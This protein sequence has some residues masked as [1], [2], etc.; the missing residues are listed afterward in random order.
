MPVRSCRIVLVVAGCAACVPPDRSPEEGESAPPPTIGHVERLAAGLDAIVAEDAVFE[1]LAEGHEWTEGPVWVPALQSILYSDIPNNAVYRWRE[2]QGASLWLQPSGYTGEAARGGESGSNGLA[3]DGEGRLVLAQHGDRR[4]ARMNA[5]LTAPE[6]RFETLTGAYEG[7]RYHSPN[8]VA[9]RGTGDL[10]FTDPPYGLEHGP[11]DPAREMDVH[12]VYHLAP[13]GA[14]TLVVGDLSRPNGVA[15]SPDERTLYVSSSDEAQPVVRAY[16][17]AD[18]GS[19]SNGRVFVESWGDGMAVDRD[20]NVFLTR[21]AD[22]VL[23][24]APDGT[25]LGTLVTTERTSNAAFG[26]D[27]SA[28]YVTS[29]MY[30][31]RIGLGGAAVVGR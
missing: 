21:G 24:I 7:R 8:D 30:L 1:I 20:G 27:G 19:L 15:F 29:D 26:D 28:L 6:A 18:D 10:Y 25:H 5:P 31:V 14:V 22:G 2:G 4:I 16:D 17:V 3:L 11:D 23:V 9:I 13:D 12:G